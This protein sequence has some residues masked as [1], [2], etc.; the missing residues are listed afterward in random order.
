[1]FT[2][3]FFASETGQLQGAHLSH[4]NIT[5]G[6][7][8]VRALMLSSNAISSLDTISSAHSLSTPFGRAVAYTAIFEGSSFATLESTKLFRIEGSKPFTTLS[9]LEYTLIA[10]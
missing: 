7:A 2:V 8:A 10:S 9:A 4:T 1:V 5:A 3:S 6:V